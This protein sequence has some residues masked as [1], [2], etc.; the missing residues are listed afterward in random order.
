MNSIDTYVSTLS[1]Y[2]RFSKENE[3]SLDRSEL[4]AFILLVRYGFIVEHKVTNSN[5]L[6]FVPDKYKLDS[7]GEKITLSHEAIRLIIDSYTPVLI[8][9]FYTIFGIEGKRGDIIDRIHDKLFLDEIT[10]ER[11][12]LEYINNQKIFPNNVSLDIVS[13]INIIKK[14]NIE[15]V[16]YPLRK[17][18]SEIGRY[19]RGGRNSRESMNLV[20]FEKNPKVIT[21]LKKIIFFSETAVKSSTLVN[22]NVFAEK[23]NSKLLFKASPSLIYDIVSSRND[24]IEID[25]VKSSKSS[26]SFHVLFSLSDVDN[27]FLFRDIATY[28]HYKG[29][30]SV[31]ESL[32]E[33]LKSWFFFEYKKLSNLIDDSLTSGF[34]IK[35]GFSN[36]TK[37][38]SN[39]Y[40]LSCIYALKEIILKDRRF[41][42]S[43]TQLSKSQSDVGLYDL[44]I[45]DRSE[46]TPTTSEFYDI[47][48]GIKQTD[49]S[50]KLLV[51][52]VIASK[53]E[54]YKSKLSTCEFYSVDSE[55]QSLSVSNENI[56]FYNRSLGDFI[57]PDYQNAVSESNEIAF[58]IA[59]IKDQQKT[60][61]KNYWFEVNE[62]LPKELRFDLETFQLSKGLDSKAE[63]FKNKDCLDA[64]EAVIVQI[65]I[66]DARS[67]VSK[68]TKVCTN[69]IKNR[70]GKLDSINKSLSKSFDE[71]L[72]KNR[73]IIEKEIAEINKRI[74]T[75]E[76]L[77]KLAEQSETTL[78]IREL[79][80]KRAD[81][82]HYISSE[83]STTGRFKEE[84][85]IHEWVVNAGNSISFDD[86][87]CEI[88]NRLSTESKSIQSYSCLFLNKNPLAIN[89]N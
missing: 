42:V 31:E 83:L 59:S 65:P 28:I 47:F 18:S 33:Y 79:T 24:F 15:V 35:K 70:Q 56:D 55:N 64:I 62:S 12:F 17:S 44:T 80:K 50:L 6:D 71:S 5:I 53:R 73:S 75:T 72:V 84:R 7:D 81:I 20:C 9:R 89:V 8:N 61:L 49:I 43:E 27:Q 52:S 46:L 63:F 22:L 41:N 3:R 69:M 11:D 60:V 14:S 40:V 29:L 25:K 67:F 51:D 78:K 21:S 54:K 48:F 87:N 77:L 4:Y 88:E 10:S 37:E 34:C 16:N 39:P 38:L 58:E 82:A 66:S 32:L 1:D 57:M 74:S 36:P 86:L 30:M 45:S 23:I 13:L 85:L 76:R 2:I 26:S 68:D 19:N